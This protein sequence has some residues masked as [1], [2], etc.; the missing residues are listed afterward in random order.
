MKLKYIEK[1][2]DSARIILK[3]MAG[4]FGCGLRTFLKP[5]N[6]WL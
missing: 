1:T 2:K 6:E 4:P 3:N 5:L